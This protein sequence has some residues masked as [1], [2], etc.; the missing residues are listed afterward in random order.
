MG[1][2]VTIYE[3][4]NRTDTIVGTISF[5]G[6]QFQLEPPGDP[7]LQ[8]MLRDPVYDPLTGHQVRAMTHPQDW[9]RSLRFQYSSP[10]L[11]ASAPVQDSQQSAPMSVDQR[12][13]SHVESGERGGQFTQ[14]G[15]EGSPAV[16]RERQSKRQFAQKRKEVTDKAGQAVKQV[17]KQALAAAV[18]AG[19][20]AGAAEHWA[21]QWTADRV[22]ALP[23]YLRLPLKALYYAG[24]GTFVAG[25]KAA[26]AVATEVG[27]EE[28]AARVG[29]TLATIDNVAALGAKGAGLAGVEGSH[30]LAVILPVASASYLAYASVRHPAATFNAAAKGVGTAMEKLKQLRAQRQDQ[31]NEQP[32]P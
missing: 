17:G 7:L 32:R 9:L 28:H 6:T 21:S 25:Q 5:N 13:V 24:F 31:P 26:K 16:S 20:K 3:I 27:G 23:A 2:K 18:L 1:L 4:R 12:G 8:R 11:R 29:A 30:V 15:N 10:Y 22:N 19:K 14:K